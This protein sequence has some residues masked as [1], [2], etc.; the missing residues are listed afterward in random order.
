MTDYRQ[1]NFLASFPKSGNTWLRCFLDAY[2][3]GKV[4]IN[5]IL[6]SV[7]DDIAFRN[8]I[9]VGGK[10]PQD[11]PVD[12]Q[13][14]TRPMA[15]LRLVLR[16]NEQDNNGIPLLVKTHNVH[17]NANGIELLPHSLTKS[18]V[19]IVR[20]PREVFMSFCRHMG[21]EDWNQ[22][23]K[24]FTDDLR[25]LSDER[26][27]KMADFI[28][29]WAKNVRSYTNAD[30]HNVRV[31]RYE[32]MKSH[33][34]ETFSG[35]L[36]HMGIEPDERRVKKALEAVTL[37]RLQKQEDKHGF[38]ESSHHQERFFGGSKDW[39]TLPPNIVYQIEKHAGS[40]MKKFGYLHE[41]AA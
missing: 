6:T 24:W 16:Y 10:E 17:M 32:D 36:R 8:G 27:A 25:V 22:G 12:I 34:V 19:Y 13:M 1:I 5:E 20:D 21:A 4:D 11:Y 23:I 7:G 39:R 41:A 38:Q 35:I 31:F 2:I 37:D 29:S 9:G 15:L 33:P 14:L 30:T 26:S 40:L 28:S 18:V 3:V